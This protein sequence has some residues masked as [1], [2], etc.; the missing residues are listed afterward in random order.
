VDLGWCAET[1]PETERVLPGD[2]SDGNPKI[3]AQGRA[4]NELFSAVSQQNTKK[5]EDLLATG[6]DLQ[7]PDKWGRT[8][9]VE[10]ANNGLN[11]L[12][13]LLLRA[14]AGANAVDSNGNTA[15]GRQY[16][17]ERIQ[18]SGMAVAYLHAIWRYKSLTTR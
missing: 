11:D 18:I 13:K 8:A 1:G 9:L 6:L 3:K 4:T 17:A 16:L 10:A 15:Y 12:A 7:Q 2:A 5:V 14:G